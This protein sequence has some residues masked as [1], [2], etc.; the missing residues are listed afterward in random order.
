MRTFPLR[1][2]IQPINF[3]HVPLFL[4][5]AIVSLSGFVCLW[6]SSFLHVPA[7]CHF[8]LGDVDL[9]NVV[10]YIKTLY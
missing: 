1:E 10:F 9:L 7:I 8:Y 5:N 4:V 3:D 2:Y 6:L